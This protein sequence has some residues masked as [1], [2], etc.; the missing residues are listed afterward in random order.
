MFIVRFI[1]RDGQPD[2]EYMYQSEKDAQY[3]FN[4]FMSDDS[5]L[6]KRIEYSKRDS[7]R[8]Y[9]TAMIEPD[10]M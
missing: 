5:G 1:R 7:H 4:L 3:H 2:E 10:E 6:Y 8:E 9:I